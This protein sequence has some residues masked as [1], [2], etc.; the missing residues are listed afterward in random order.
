MRRS[1]CAWRPCDAVLPSVSNGRCYAGEGVRRGVCAAG[2][3]C[4]RTNEDG[5]AHIVT[6]ESTSCNSNSCELLEVMRNVV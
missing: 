2:A 6:H 4:V 3:G 5:H 1:S